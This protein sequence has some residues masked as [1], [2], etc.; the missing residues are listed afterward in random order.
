MVRR[1]GNRTALALPPGDTL[2]SVFLTQAA[3]RPDQPIFADQS[4]GTR[5]YRDLV[6]TVRSCS[7]RGSNGCRVDVGITTPAS[8]GATVFLLATLFAGKTPVMVNWTAG[9]RA[10]RHSLDTLGVTTVV[11][12]RAL[13]A[14]LG[15]LGH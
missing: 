13:V 12:A 14:K 4:S 5:T 10:L 2:T 8:V 1:V 9:T 3:A 11:T 15:F 7:S 6:T